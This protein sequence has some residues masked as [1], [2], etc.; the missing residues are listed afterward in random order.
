[1]PGTRGSKVAGIVAVKPARDKRS[2]MSVVSAK[3]ESGRVFLRQRAP[4]LLISNRSFMTINAI[5]AA[6]RSDR[7]TDY[8]DHLAE[9]A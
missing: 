1:M 5:P 6:R 8:D 7:I 3:F 9:A 2:R 4:W